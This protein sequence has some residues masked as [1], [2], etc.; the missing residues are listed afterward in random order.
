M[1]PLRRRSFAL[2][3]FGAGLN[4]I[5]TWATLI[6]LWGYAAY[7]FHATPGGIAAIGLCWALPGALLCPIAGIPIDRLGPRRVLIASNLLGAATSATMI[8]AGSLGPL[9]ALALVHGAVQAFGRPAAASLPPRLVDDDELL[10]ANSLL[11]AAEQSSIVFGPLV[12]AVAIT[13]WSLRGAFLIDALTFV[14]GAVS[15]V[16]IRPSAITPAPRTSVL[17]DLREAAGL[18][19]R[20]PPVRFTLALSS[21]V[22]LMWAAFFV[23]EPIYVRDVLHR[24]PTVLGVFQSVFGVGL[25]AT[26]LLL[27]RLGDRVATAWTVAL[28]VVVSGVAAALYVGTR[29]IEVAT[30]AVFAWGIAVAFFVAPSRTLLQ[31]SAPPATHGRM[32]GFTEMLDGWAN[33]VSIP[34]TGVVIASIGVGP[35]GVG[36]GA[37][38]MAAGV[39]GLAAARRSPE[40]SAAAPDAA[41]ARHE[42]PAP[43]GTPEAKNLITTG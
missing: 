33:L 17:T 14:V 25:V 2:F 18:A 1:S 30:I 23:I 37:L 36:V 34:V 27:P 22:Y 19:R 26:S 4:A 43:S 12:G 28:S 41:P 10:A 42:T 13:V 38:A 21:A 40:L 35:T 39:A 9:L 31:R 11:G 16:P 7:R 32:F 5:G 8:L 3:I 6:A 29:S 24:S 15:L 20:L